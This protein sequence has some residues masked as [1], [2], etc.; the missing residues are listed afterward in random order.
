MR[1][2]SIGRSKSSTICIPNE[3]VSANH[4]ELVLLDNGD[5]FLIDCN[6]RHGTFLFGK[7]IAPNVEVPVRR[8]DKIDFDQVPLDWSKVPFVPQPDM[9]IV[10]GVYGIG[11]NARNRYRLSGDTVSRYHATFKEMKNGKWYIQDHSTNGTYVNG[12][13]IPSN[14]DYRI[15]SRDTIVCGSVPCPNPVPKPKMPWQIFVGI[16]AAAAVVALLFII[17]PI[18][19]KINPEKAVA[20]V[21]QVYR[22]KVVFAD[23]PEI[24][25]KYFGKGEWYIEEDRDIGIDVLNRLTKNKDNALTRV[26]CG[27][28]F[29]VSDKGL[30]LTNKHVTDWIWAD[31]TYNGGRNVDYYKNKIES[32]RS[33]TC[34]S[35]VEAVNLTT[36]E[37][38]AFDLW[39]K[40]P[41]TFEIETVFLGVRLSGKTYS[42]LDEYERAHIE[43]QSTKDDI[44]MAV[45]RLNSMVTPEFVDYF[46]MKDAI[47]DISKLKMH[48]TNYYTIGYPCGE[49]DITNS[50]SNAVVTPTFGLLHLVQA[51]SKNKL[52]MKGDESVS[53][54]SG[55]PIYDDHNRLIGVLWGGWTATESTG[56]CPIENA[57]D[58]LKEILDNDTYQELYKS[59]A[60]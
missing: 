48:G 55:S 4:A 52:F 27:T 26:H 29:F 15:T 6:S 12:Q 34:E 58:L 3:Y 33:A 5:I 54:Q 47:C 23:N 40:S 19:H 28:A 2:I 8:G 57:D 38:A 16:G 49:A 13:R 60:Y 31:K 18:R 51:P 1:L 17:L 11:K 45:I 39:L 25:N 22:I 50:K 41:F 35:I 14:Q 20:L 30:M 59:K 42:S 10:K 36:S 37:K 24:L 43:A 21:T 7:Q 44:D 46:R 9:R 56:G 32:C 53:G